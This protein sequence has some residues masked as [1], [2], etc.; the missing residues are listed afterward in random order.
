MKKIIVFILISMLM[1][2]CNTSNKSKV[3]RDGEPDI[4]NVDET[5]FAMNDAMNKAKNTI[6]LFEEAFENKSDKNSYSLKQKFTSV[7]GESEH[8][9]I[10]EIE[11][12]NTDFYGVVNNEPFYVTDIKYGSSVKVDMN[13]L[14]DWMVIENETGKVKGGYTIKVLRDEMSEDEKK[15]FDIDSGLIFE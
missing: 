12:K 1:Y 7:D 10:G 14:S 3:E 15:Q 8:I 6:N 5:D 13:E 4:Y 11:K 9:W 2:S